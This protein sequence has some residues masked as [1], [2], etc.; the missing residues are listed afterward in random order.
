[1][2]H[3]PTPLPAVAE[4]YSAMRGESLEPGGCSVCPT[5]RLGERDH[6]L[7]RAVPPRRRRGRGGRRS[8]RAAVACAEH[9]GEAGGGC[10]G[11][12]AA[13]AAAVEVGGRG[14]S[15]GPGLAVL[16]LRDAGQD[17]VDAHRPG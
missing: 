2:H 8:G 11:G 6:A 13:V 14:G 9:A 5:S 3:G 1:M 17:G 7:R 10:P 15:G 16:D 4:R 12:G